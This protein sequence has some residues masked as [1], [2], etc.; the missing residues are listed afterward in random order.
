MTTEQTPPVNIEAEE[1]VLGKLL[2]QPD[3]VYDVMQVLP[4]E[5]FYFR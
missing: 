4:E 3:A 5:A 1:E 2:F